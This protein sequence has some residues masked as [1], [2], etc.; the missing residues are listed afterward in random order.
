[1]TPEEARVFVRAPL[2][3]TGCEHYLMLRTHSE[4]STPQ[5]TGCIK[6]RLPFDPSLQ[7]DAGSTKVDSLEQDQVV[8]TAKL[9]EERNVL[10]VATGE[11]VLSG[12]KMAVGSGEFGLMINF[13]RYSD[14]FVGSECMDFASNAVENTPDDSDEILEEITVTISE[15]VEKEVSR[16]VDQ[17]PDPFFSEMDLVR[18]SVGNAPRA[19]ADVSEEISINTIKEGKTEISRIVIQQPESVDS[20][21]DSTV[22]RRSPTPTCDQGSGAFTPIPSTIRT[23]KEIQIEELDRMEEIACKLAESL[24]EARK[25]LMG[26]EHFRT[27]KTM[28]NLGYGYRQYGWVD[29]GMRLLQKAVDGLERVV[30]KMNVD[31]LQAMYKLAEAKFSQR[32]FREAWWQFEKVLEGRVEVL[33]KY[34][35]TTLDTMKRLE[36]IFGTCYDFMGHFYDGLQLLEFMVKYQIRI[37]GEDHQHTVVA[38]DHLVK[39]HAIWTQ[40]GVEFIEVQLEGCLKSMVNRRIPVLA[41]KGGNLE[42]QYVFGKISTLDF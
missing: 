9:L 12:I 20:E 14:D 38:M 33:G 36:E 19:I 7:F 17:Q 29:E 2:S 34:H 30:G 1:M 31:T 11:W 32:K 13:W 26:E 39:H 3:P 41:E 42:A 35:P 24:G 37:R 6:Y 16:N 22:G 40:D 21:L 25:I 23:E 10:T 15:K 18:E 4:Y 8:A 27:F 28:A 5:E